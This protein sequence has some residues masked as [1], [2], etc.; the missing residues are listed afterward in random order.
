MPFS[1]Q[2]KTLQGSAGRN[3]NLELPLQ[4]VLHLLVLEA[5]DE[6]VEHG[7]YDGVEDEH[8]LAT[9]IIGESMRLNVCENYCAIE[10]GNG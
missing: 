5:T 6:G 1:C 9:G 4:G 7:N 10:T 2:Q 3:V 8:Y